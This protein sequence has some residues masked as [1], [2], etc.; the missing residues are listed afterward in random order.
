[1]PRTLIENLLF[2]RNPK[3]RVS[4][5]S[6]LMGP[7]KVVVSGPEI[8]S[9]RQRFSLSLFLPPLGARDQH[10]ALDGRCHHSPLGQAVLFVAQLICKFMDR[11]C[12]LEVSPAIGCGDPSKHW[13]PRGSN[14]LLLA[15]EVDGAK[16]DSSSLRRLTALQTP[17]Q[18]LPKK[19]SPFLCDG[20]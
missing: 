10:Q 2:C 17:S 15:S 4:T 11:A 16:K 19:E 12:S 6:R 8:E 5:R 3:R 13:G 14:A 18:S 7:T 20:Q 9:S 1:M